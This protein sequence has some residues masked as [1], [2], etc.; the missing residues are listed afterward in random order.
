ML[1]EKREVGP[2]S[3]HLDVALDVKG[4]I[5]FEQSLLLAEGGAEDAPVGAQ[6][7]GQG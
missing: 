6:S 1:S 2:G 4:A 5:R 7:F 3:K